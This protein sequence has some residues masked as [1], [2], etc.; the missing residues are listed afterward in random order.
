MDEVL[1][2]FAQAHGE[3]FH[4]EAEEFEQDFRNWKRGA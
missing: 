3:A 2:A 1:Q 4:E